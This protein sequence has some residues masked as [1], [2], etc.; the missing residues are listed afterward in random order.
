MDM[1]DRMKVTRA[2]VKEALRL[3]TPA[4]ALPRTVKKDFP[5]TPG[6][7][8]KRGQLLMPSVWKIT[9]DPVAYPDPD[10]F[11]PERWLFGD[12]ERQ[13]KNWVVFGSDPHSCM[14]KVYAM[15]H[16]MTLIGKASIER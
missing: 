9:H 14:G 13:T 10:A 12:A 16:L 4:I 2:V 3:R 15:A 1:L 11:K 6:F 7:I 5:L 8:A